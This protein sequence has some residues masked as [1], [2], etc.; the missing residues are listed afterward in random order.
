MFISCRL[1]EIVL[2]KV[3]SCYQKSAIKR[4]AAFS[5]KVVIKE[6]AQVAK[7]YEMPPEAAFKVELV[8]STTRVSLFGCTVNLPECVMTHLVHLHPQPREL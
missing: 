5:L 7:P 6:G 3:M 1:N 2:L 8:D 4:K